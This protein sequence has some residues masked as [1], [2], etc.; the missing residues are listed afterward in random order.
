[1][2]I[3]YQLANI[4]KFCMDFNFQGCSRNE[5]LLTQE[6][7]VLMMN[8]LGEECP[9]LI[10]IIMKFRSRASPFDKS[11]LF[12][13][14][15]VKNI[16]PYTWWLNIDTSGGA[17][18]GELDRNTRDLIANLHRS[19]ASS[20]SVER[21][22]STFGFVHSAVRNRLGIEKAGKLVF[23]FRVLNNN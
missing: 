1:M 14:M 19:V 23:L 17:G 16:L 2:H 12:A 21:M 9:K 18:E 22:F 6:E 15:T 20:A 4:N 13:P 10:P 7:D 3:K 11:Y 8:F 5:S